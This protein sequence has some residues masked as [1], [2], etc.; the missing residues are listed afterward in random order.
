MNQKKLK[1]LSFRKELPNS[2]IKSE[3]QITNMIGEFKL[4]EKESANT[5]S[6]LYQKCEQYKINVKMTS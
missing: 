2:P 4:K 3:N 5:I 6:D 1:L